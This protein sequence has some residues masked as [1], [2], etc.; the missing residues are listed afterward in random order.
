MCF[1]CKQKTASEWR[2]S[3]WSSDVCSPDLRDAA[4][5]RRSSRAEVRNPVLALPAARLIRAMPA[6]I[7]AL[8]AVLLL[9]LAADARRRSRTSW[10]NRKVFV[11]AYWA[12]VAVYAGHVARVLEIGRAHV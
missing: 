6:N 12:T 7:R 3:D 8:L 9:D 4:M 2:I 5:T 1:F 11:A 10:E